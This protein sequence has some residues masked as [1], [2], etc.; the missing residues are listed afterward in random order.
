VNE[1][2]ELSDSVRSLSHFDFDVNFSVAHISRM[3]KEMTGII[4]LSMQYM[5]NQAGKIMGR[6]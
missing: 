1:T 2:G 5:S 3:A 4:I 6:K